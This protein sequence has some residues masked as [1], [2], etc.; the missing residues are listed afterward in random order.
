M[1]ASLTQSPGNAMTAMI[2]QADGVSVPS[3]A[4]PVTIAFRSSTITSGATTKI[5]VMSSIS[6]T[7]PAG[8]TIGTS[9]GYAGFI[10]VYALN[11]A[12]LSNLQCLSAVSSMFWTYYYGGCRRRVCDYSAHS[13]TA[14]VGVPIA[15]IG[16]ML[17]PQVTAGTWAAAATEVFVAS[18]YDYAAAQILTTRGDRIYSKQF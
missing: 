9:N 8:T 17:A 7:I 11:S 4:N 14:R 1:S 12:A 5:S 18:G 15:Y 13:T 16:K 10:Y 6:I 3:V 2:T